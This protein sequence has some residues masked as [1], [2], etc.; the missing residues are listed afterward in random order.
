MA[1]ENEHIIRITGDPGNNAASQRN[2]ADGSE[3][4]N[5]Q[6]PN[7]DQNGESTEESIDT[8]IQQGTLTE[9]EKRKLQEP[10]ELDDGSK[11]SALYNRAIQEFDPSEIQN[12]QLAEHW[13]YNDSEYDE[14]GHF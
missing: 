5:S 10:V 4:N 8:R 6:P 13:K 14:Y 2:G 1:S 7:Q 9:D 12:V 3:P 11:V